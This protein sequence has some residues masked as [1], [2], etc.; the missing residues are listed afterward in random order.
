[1][2][3][4]ANT[5]TEDKR[6]GI[7]GGGQLGRM[8]A[9]A[10]I[11]LGLEFVFLDPA[12]EACA[13]A[14]G[15][16]ILAD[17]DDPDALQQLIQR[18]DIIT[19]EFENI[20]M[21]A[22]HLTNAQTRLFPPP[23]ALEIAQDRVNEKNLFAQLDIPTPPWRA[24]DSLIEL[25]QAVSDIGLPAVL[26]TRRM[27]YDGKGQS[28][29]RHP[30]DAQAAWESLGGAALILEGFID[31]E[32]EVSLIAVR[33][34]SGEL[35]FYPLSENTHEA[36]ILKLSLSR[37]ND[38]MQTQ[39]EAHARRVLENMNYVGT[40]GFEFFVAKQGLIANEIA[41]RVHNTG[42]WTIEGAATSQFENHL[43]AILD[44]PLGSTALRGAC[45]MLNFI[46]DLPSRQQAMCIK[47]VH[48]HAYG[49]DARAGRKVGHATLVTASEAERE[50]RLSELFALV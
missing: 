16:Q 50:V 28:V 35:A 31:F 36:G 11:P 14:L 9:L 48:F 34:R 19:L 26:K 43:R 32:R 15:E 40:L 5:F 44:L 13:A 6:I 39:A 22:L 23:L 8:L 7:I 38:P 45:A 4:T 47:D 46:G 2:T 27:G 24:V 20:P 41:P 29:L 30:D 1:M 21:P 37:E 17:Y 3:T 25:Q 33:S 12:H 18:T 10:G 42:H 49:K